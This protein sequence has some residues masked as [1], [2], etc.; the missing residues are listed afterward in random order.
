[1]FP[2]IPCILLHCT[3]LPCLVP[4]VNTGAPEIY[5][6]F[7][8]YTG[9]RYIIMLTND[10]IAWRM[11]FFSNS[12]TN[13][14]TWKPQ[15]KVYMHC[16]QLVFVTISSHWASCASVFAHPPVGVC[17]P[18]CAVLVFFLHWFAHNFSL[19]WAYNCLGEE[20]VCCFK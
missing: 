12:C 4:L 11:S 15:G 16:W 3:I 8:P 13:G 17:P 19:L 1:M 2:S 20:E 5:S 18:Q 9:S 7:L 14:S 6:L 10:W